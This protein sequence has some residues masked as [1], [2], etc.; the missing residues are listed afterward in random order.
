MEES[1]IQGRTSGKKKEKQKRQ[2]K[3]FPFIY[4][5][6]VVPRKMPRV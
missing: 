4:Y 6:D 3:R 2:R 5:E 1:R